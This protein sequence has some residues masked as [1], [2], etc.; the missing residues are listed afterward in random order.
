MKLFPINRNAP[1]RFAPA[2]PHAA[3]VVVIGGGIIGVMTAWFLA[4]AGVQVVL[5]EKGRIAGEQSG[6]NWGW[7]RKQGRDPAE[8]PLMIE[9]LQIWRGLEAQAGADL[10][11][12]ETGVMY[13]ANGAKDMAQYEDWIAHAHAHGLDTKLLT[14]AAV[15]AMLPNAA[16][17]AGGIWTASDARAEPWKAVPALALAAGRM[18]ASLHE[19]CAVRALDVAA[20]RVIGVITERGRIRADRVV[21]AGGVWSSLLA[22]AHGVILPQLSFLATVSA[23]VPLDFGF[24]GAAADNHFAFRKRQDG[25]LTLTPG[26]AHDFFIGPDAFRH[27]RAFLPVLRKDRAATRFRRKAPPDYPDAWGTPRHWDADRISPFERIRILD[28][29]PDLPAIEDIR[30]RFAAA[31][32]KI[33]KPAIAGA[34][35]GMI[36]TMPD[37]VPVIGPAAGLPG[38]TIATGLSGHGFGIGPAVG[39]VVADLVQGR[40]PGHDLSRFRLSRFSDGSKIVIG[41]AL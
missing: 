37:V 31:F 11:F 3:D 25:G 19:D 27:F 2:P 5:C 6:R 32:P 8:L 38:L 4:K 30:G 15:G 10:G 9:A 39:R 28:P 24:D 29:E 17:W 14:A 20:G 40:S 34:W 7:V 12:R 23:T 21:L 16:G 36:D 41:P 22:R 33:G 26:S 13:L 1:A 18:G 35:A